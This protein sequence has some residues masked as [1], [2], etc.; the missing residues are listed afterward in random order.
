[1]STN[2]RDKFICYYPANSGWK[3]GKAWPMESYQN[4][5]WEFQFDSQS[6][7]CSAVAVSE[8]GFQRKNGGSVASSCELL[9]NLVFEVCWSCGDL[10]G[11]RFFNSI[12]EP[13]AC[14][15]LWEVLEAA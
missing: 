11:L 15:D 14:D 9:S 6:G 12:L 8:G 1:M 4:P 13:D 5:L 2:Y 3:L 7:S 10:T